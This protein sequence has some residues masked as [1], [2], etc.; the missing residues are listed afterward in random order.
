MRNLLVLRLRFKCLHGNLHE[1]TSITLLAR[2]V[3][4]HTI[5][6]WGYKTPLEYRLPLWY[7]TE[8]G[9]KIDSIQE[10]KL[11]PPVEKNSEVF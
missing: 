6:N 11:P 7:E 4:R 3:L 8:L 9:T 2:A 5:G 10:M 1:A